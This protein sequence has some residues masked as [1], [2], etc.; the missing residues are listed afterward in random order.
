MNS[1]RVG[2]YLMVSLWMLRYHMK[3]G[4]YSISFTA[5]QYWCSDP[6]GWD[7]HFRRAIRWRVWNPFHV[8]CCW[9]HFWRSLPLR[10]LLT[11]GLVQG[12]RLV[13]DACRV[14]LTGSPTGS[15]VQNSNSG[16]DTTLILH[17][18][19]RESRC[20]PKSPTLQRYSPIKWTVA[21]PLQLSQS[22]ISKALP[23][24]P[25]WK[26]FRDPFYPPPVLLAYQHPKP[27][28]LRST[29]C[30]IPGAPKA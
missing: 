22:P 13:L 10:A 5:C 26:S 14:V 21:I 11:P 20:A 12:L 23:L 18:Q 27:I 4:G 2:R 15:G 30:P 1:R 3:H 7:S 16:A 24:Q 25:R 6:H 29:R 8:S 19:C 17:Q 9:W 28:S